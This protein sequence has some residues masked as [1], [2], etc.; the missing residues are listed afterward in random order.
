MRRLKSQLHNRVTY[1]ITYSHIH[2]FTS[3]I[4]TSY[5]VEISQKSVFSCHFTQ[6]LKLLRNRIRESGTKVS[7]IV[8]LHIQYGVVL[9]IR[10]W[11]W[12]L[13]IL[14]WLCWCF[15]VFFSRKVSSIVEYVTRQNS[16]Y[17]IQTFE[18]SH[19]TEW[20][21]NNTNTVLLDFSK[22]WVAV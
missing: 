2:I 11:G 21:K 10:L 16:T 7:S 4:F 6:R 19:R 1:S 20:D 8:V 3:Y 13:R 9:H 18:K 12:L 22:V 14:I 17:S 5:S 15:L